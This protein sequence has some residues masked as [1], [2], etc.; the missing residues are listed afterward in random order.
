MSRRR[1]RRALI[2]A[3]VDVLEPRR[4]LSTIYVDAG[5]TGA[6]HDG[7]SWASASLDLQPVLLAAASGDRILV[8]KGTYRPT[9]KADRTVSFVLKNGVEVSGGYGGSANS[10]D[11]DFRSPLG[12]SASDITTMSELGSQASILRLTLA[13]SP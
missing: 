5:A 3:S 12:A 9:S 11:P 2:A 6:V 1:G 7:T 4:L 10:G 8:A 13:V